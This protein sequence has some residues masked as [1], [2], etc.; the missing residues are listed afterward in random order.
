MTHNYSYVID[1]KYFFESCFFLFPSKSRKIFQ[2]CFD[3][4][5]IE[6]RKTGVLLSLVPKM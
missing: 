6:L 1:D 5:E 2:M 3:Q 4:Y